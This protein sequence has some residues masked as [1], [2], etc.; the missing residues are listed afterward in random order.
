MRRF[1]LSVTIS[2][3]DHV[4]HEVYRVVTCSQALTSEEAQFIGLSE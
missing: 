1:S 2:A 3:E 4:Q